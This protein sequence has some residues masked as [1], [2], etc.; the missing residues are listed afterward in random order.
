MK[1]QV[2]YAVVVLASL[3]VPRAGPA[4]DVVGP[5]SAKIDA[6]VHKRVPDNGPG[7]AVAVVDKGKIAHARGYG[8][9]DIENR[10]PIHPETL[11]DLASVS[12]QFTAMAVMMLA[13]EG[14]LAF[15][16]DART[17]LP[18]L[19]QHNPRRPIRIA[20]LLHHTSGLPDYMGVWEGTDEEF[21][22][23]TNEGVLKLI[24]K[25]K[26]DFPT[27][28]KHDYSNTN[29]VLLAIIVER[30][31]KKP[32]DRYLREKI[33]DPLKMQRTRINRGDVLKFSNLALGYKRRKNGT[34][35][36]SYSP[37][38][39][40][41]DGNVFSCVADLALW[42]EGLRTN[43]LV[44]EKML[45]RAMKSGKLDDGTEHGY[46]FGW[47]DDTVDDRRSFGHSGGW[48]GYENYSCRYLDL[49]AAIFVLSNNEDFDSG[50]L[51]DAIAE[52]YF[53]K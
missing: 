35:A 38:V 40:T 16:D 51:V 24:A 26:L 39:V 48:Y 37:A 43:Q 18:E 44:S 1:R 3:L 53:A 13:E 5:R 10:R 25:H 31:A 2:S 4:E 11:F 28:T 12:K 20:D 22:V 50:D 46:G 36:R 42:E 30:V 9:A 14:K 8:L 17:H 15:N 33:F 27:G 21:A 47:S 32:F 6:V 49:D 19:K 29:Y 34:A 23:L 41:G 45:R 7:V 52:V